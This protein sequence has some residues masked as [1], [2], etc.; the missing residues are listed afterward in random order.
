MNTNSINKPKHTYHQHW[1]MDDIPWQH[2]QRDLVAHQEEL[3]YLIAVASFIEI[4]TDL[5]TSNLLEYFFDD[6]EVTLWLNQHWE[7]E[8]LQHGNSLKRY[9]QTAW[10]EFDWEKTYAAFLQEYS[11][12]CRL[13]L[14]EPTRS[15]EMAARCVVEMG[16]ASYYT[17]LS[18]LSP[19]PVLSVLTHHIREDEVRHYKHF[20]HYFLRY[21]EREGTGRAR[22]L[23]AL[24]HRLKMI[25]GEDG[26]IAIKHVYLASHSSQPFDMRVYRDLR[27]R[28]KHKV[29]KYVPLEMSIKMLIK[30]LD[31]SPSMQHVAVP[32]LAGLA[33]CTVV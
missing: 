5:Y 31:L 20:Y 27:K 10:P 30:P 28:Y 3:F 1:T 16:T 25:D 18:R 17:A 29:R 21:R 9:V 2:I 22:V 8:E 6:E 4:T 15:M 11:Q 26:L 24:W 7:R 12:Y 33:R 32:V 14:L 13:D 19:D 23:K